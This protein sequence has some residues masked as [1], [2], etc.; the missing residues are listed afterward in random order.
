MRWVDLLANL[1]AAFQEGRRA[2]SRFRAR[3]GATTRDD[4]QDFLVQ[5]YRES[6]EQIRQA[7]RLRMS[8]LVAVVAGSLL[9][10]QLA[11][12]VDFVLPTLRVQ[13]VEERAAW[14]IVMALL[15]VLS[16]AGAAITAVTR[17][18]V[19]RAVDRQKKITLLF[20]SRA[21]LDKLDSYH[22]R[23]PWT[24]WPYYVIYLVFGVGGLAG[25]LSSL[26]G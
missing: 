19:T 22:E 3:P 23:R 11:L 26:Y 6:G 10:V 18:F 4:D 21:T 15:L 16:I 1:A 17:R 7:E 20:V 13:P 14:I 9:L 25:V 24:D 8:L 5:M 12:Y 2:D